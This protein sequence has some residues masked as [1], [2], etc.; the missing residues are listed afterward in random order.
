MCEVE[1]SFEHQQLRELNSNI[2]RDNRQAIERNKVQGLRGGGLRKGVKRLA[3]P[4]SLFKTEEFVYKSGK[5]MSGIWYAE[6]ILK[7]HLFPY[8]IAVRESNPDAY[9]YLVQDNVYLHSLGMRY[10]QPEVEALRIKSA[11]HPPNSPDL[12]PI[13]PCFG[14]LEGF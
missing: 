12:H 11:H 2:V 4:K 14:R 6:E 10:C 5:G 1:G 9:I 3:T 7:R 13:E 8:Y